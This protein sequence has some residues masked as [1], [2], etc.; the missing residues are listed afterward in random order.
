MSCTSRAIASGAW[1]PASAR[2]SFTHAGTPC[3]LPLF[4]NGLA[5]LPAL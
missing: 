3:G 4:A 1:L 5:L 2:I